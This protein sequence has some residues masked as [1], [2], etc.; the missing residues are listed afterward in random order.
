MIYSNVD[1]SN[2]PD[3]EP[4]M[5]TNAGQMNTIETV[6]IYT[7]KEGCLVG[8]GHM[9]LYLWKCMP[10]FLFTSIPKGYPK[11]VEMSSMGSSDKWAQRTTNAIVH[12]PYI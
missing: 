1:N 3:L 2:S 7:A 10:E 6:N 5:H 8:K 11:V 9:N 4:E 12:D